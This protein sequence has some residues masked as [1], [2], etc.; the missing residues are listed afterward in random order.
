MTA[1]L[2]EKAARLRALHGD[3]RV[4][5][6]PNAWDAPSAAVIERAGAA[7]IATSS[8]GV[9]W[10]LGY[11][12]GERLTRDEMLEAVGRI[13][14]AV[15][16]PV[17][18]DVE[19]GYGPAPSDVAATVAGTIGAGAVGINLEDSAAPGELFSADAQAA[20][21]HEARNAAVAAGTPSFVINARTDVYLRQIGEPETRFDAVVER[22]E[23]YAAGGADCLFVPGLLDLE[24]L[25]ALVG[26]SPIPVSVLARPGGPT[27]AE[28]ASTGVRRV[29]VGPAISEAVY[30]LAGRA[31]RELLEYGTYGSLE[32]AIAFTE[33]QSLVG[34]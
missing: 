28:L 27:I 13:A 34:R 31:A 1:P 17:T 12:D 18:A 10:T 22:G 4:L 30:A 7:A 6:L 24:T 11:P 2:E 21:I 19:A 26:V 29:S 33:L 3:G 9:A 8:A 25:E 15:D 32:D 23:A 14:A 16:V 20:R 5:V